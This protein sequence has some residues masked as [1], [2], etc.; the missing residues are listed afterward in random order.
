MI[1]VTGGTGL[2]GSHLLYFLL[3][4]NK[5]VRAIKR[6]TSNLEPAKSV[7]TSYEAT[8]LFNKIDWVTADIMDVPTLEDAFIDVTHVYHCAAFVSFATADYHQLLKINIEG[9]ANVVNLCIANNI[10]KL[11][12][13]SSVAAL[14]ESLNGNPISEETHWNPEANNNGY[15]ISKFGGEMEVWRG[16]QE[17]LE[18]IIVQPSV[19][20]GEGHWNSASGK[21]FTTIKKGI[22]KYPTGSTGFVDVQD[23]AQSLNLLM[24]SEI[25]NESFV[26]SANNLSY[27][28]IITQIATNIGIKPPKGAVQTWQLSLLSFFQKVAGVFTR[29]SP[30]LNK[31]SINSLQKI[32]EYNGDKITKTTSFTYNKIDETINRVSTSFKKQH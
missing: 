31:E 16:S 24:D 32:S 19:I 29:K 10:K 12:H 9:T 17:G 2:V 22:P 1:L 15:A 8:P 26:L 6:S 25:I 7:F 27:Q 13:V 18:V 4:E 14:G 3:K 30:S 23:V 20:I 5:T 11:C 21:L 28:K